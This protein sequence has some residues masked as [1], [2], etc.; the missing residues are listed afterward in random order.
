[1]ITYC[2]INTCE[3]CP[4]YG[5]DCDG[6]KRVEHT[7]LI[8]RADAIE[9]I[10]SASEE[11]NY[12]HEGEDWMNGLCQAEQIIDALPSAEAA[13]GWIPYSE[14]RPSEDGCGW[15]L[16]TVKGRHGLFVDVAPFIDELWKGL[17]IAWMPLPT[18]YKGG[19]E[20]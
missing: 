10:A 17:V 18:P 8:S 1:M 11:P 6:D 14:R 16:V 2:D 12:Q 19:D 13:Q 5:D 20:E 3:E 15:Y 9:A 7:D 4:R